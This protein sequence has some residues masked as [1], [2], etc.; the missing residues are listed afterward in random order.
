MTRDR[1]ILN[2]ADE[3]A[4]LVNVQVLSP[5]ALIVKL[6]ELSE[7]QRYEPNF[8]SGLNLRWRRLRSQEISSFPFN[9]F[10]EHDEALGRL[11]DLVGIL[12]SDPD[13]HEVEVLWLGREPLALRG[14]AS[15]PQRGL[16]ITLGRVADSYDRS[17]FGRFLISDA[18]YRALEMG[19][20]M[21]KLENSSIPAGLIQGLAD[22]GF[23]RYDSQFVRFCFTRYMDN[24]R[25]FEAIEELCPEV[26][27]RFRAGSLSELEASCSPLFT[28]FDQNYFLIPIRE[29]Y[30]INLIDRGTGCAGSFRWES[31]T[32]C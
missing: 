22:M 17:L 28:S 3:I 31:P 1:R 5:T 27:D 15:R 14:L 30:A 6:N 18:V 8:V 2:K 23:R 10:L 9:R 32:C 12:L 11:R 20:E 16:A 25:A 26:A 13:P 21:V 19:L 24:N 29:G 4:G 7:A